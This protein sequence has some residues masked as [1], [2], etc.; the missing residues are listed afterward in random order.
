MERGHTWTEGAGKEA[1]GCADWGAHSSEPWGPLGFLMACVYPW[2][3]LM[4]CEVTRS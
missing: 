2:D 4:Y 3:R 1:E